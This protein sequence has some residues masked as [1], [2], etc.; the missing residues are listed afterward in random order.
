MSTRPHPPLFAYVA[1]LSFLLLML[2]P[3]W[4]IAQDGAQDGAPAE[5]S[6]KAPAAA[7]VEEAEEPEEKVAPIDYEEMEA[8]EE[9]ESE[10]WAPRVARGGDVAPESLA[11]YQGLLASLRRDSGLV[12][13]LY[14]LPERAPSGSRML[15][16]AEVRRRLTETKVLGVSVP[17]DH[18]HVRGYLDFFDGRGKRTI[19]GWL[20]RMAIYEPM[21]RQVFREEGL[22]EDL[23]FVAMIESG[24]SP[25]ARSYASAVGLWQFIAKTGRGMGLEIDRYVDERRDPVK[26]TRAAA[27]YLKLLH[28]RYDSWP[29]AL[30]AYN[31]GPGRVSGEMRRLNT[32]DYW[33]LV[34][35]GGMHGE[36]RRYVAKVLTVG[37][38]AKNRDLF[39]LNGLEVADALAFDLVDV[40]HNPSSLKAVA[41]AAGCSVD[42]LRD[43]N[44]ELKTAST[45]PSKGSYSLRI[46]A[47][48]AARYVSRL[49]KVDLSTEGER[50]LHEVAFGETMDM[51]AARHG[52]S[53]RVIRAANG[54]GR[55]ARARYGETLSIPKDALGT[56]TPKA[57][58]DKDDE[59][60]V[61]VPAD[62]FIQDGQVR[63]YYETSRGDT[64]RGIARGFGLPEGDVALWNDLDPSAKLRR[65]LVL[66]LF[67]PEGA[68]PGS[69]ALTEGAG[70]DVVAEGSEAYAS[71]VREAYRQKRA[72]TK[73]GSR[74]NHKVRKGD[75]LWIIA[76]KHKTTVEKI[77]RLNRKLRKRDTLQIGEKIRV[78]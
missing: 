66:Q 19:A 63:R 67:F 51:V 35:H 71:K 65:G 4:A 68:V 78:R 53:P 10:A 9:L 58:K 54:M 64:L 36:A 56:W 8:L 59:R 24:F 27:R 2:S 14:S 21:I 31:G 33:A 62:A 45:P 74:R 5:V 72:R 7:D 22:P 48:K 41:D 44:P 29:L 46:P 20:R 32:N 42:D 73:G 17:L 38:I 30:A 13:E 75:S 76:K 55:R 3:A 52:V 15:D 11:P 25:R 12:P 61:L 1:P 70:Y 16:L 49:D 39:G 34:R 23:I 47:G 77:R 18:E 40:H 57:S 28:E 60:V 69:L 37:L 6:A 26:S 43:L 50:V